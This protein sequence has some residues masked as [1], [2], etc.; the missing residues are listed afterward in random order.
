MSG[1]KCGICVVSLGDSSIG[2]DSCNSR[3]HPTP[4]CLGLPNSIIDTIN[5][6]GDRNI[7]FC[8]TSFR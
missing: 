6:Y 3:Y 5:E 1:V 7:N 8:C 2:C 4:I